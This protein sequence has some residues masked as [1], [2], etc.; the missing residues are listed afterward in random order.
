MNGNDNKL[1]KIVS[2]FLLI[3]LV[4]LNCQKKSFEY[5]DVCFQ[6]LKAVEAQIFEI[7]KKYP[8]FSQVAYKNN[9]NFN[10]VFRKEKSKFIMNPKF[11]N[12][13]N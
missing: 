13:I 4:N 1:N 11:A 9:Y 6:A 12:A 5:S 8:I 10:A 2:I 7:F 3:S